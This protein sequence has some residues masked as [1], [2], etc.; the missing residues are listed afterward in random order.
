MTRSLR[1]QVTGQGGHP[2]LRRASVAGAL[3]VLIL[4]LAGCGDP[5]DDDDGGYLDQQST[6]QVLTVGR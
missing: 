1:T 6:E 4:G 3:V 2:R 5:D